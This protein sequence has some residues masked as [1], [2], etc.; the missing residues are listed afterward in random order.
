M[1]EVEGLKKLY[2]RKLAVSGVN[3][4]MHTGEVVG[5]LGPNGAGKTTVFYMIAGF[6]EP[7]AGLVKLDSRPLN[8]L[9]MFKR[10]RLGIAYLPQEPSIFR[11]MSVEDN[12]LAVL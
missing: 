6:L 10:A 3:F 12:I 9:P 2:G 4:S 5:L 11:K 7:T 1:L 8:A